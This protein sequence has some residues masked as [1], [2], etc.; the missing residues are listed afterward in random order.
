MWG[1]SE[2]HRTSRPCVDCGPVHGPGPGGRFR[3]GLSANGRGRALLAG[4]GTGMVT[5][6]Q[7][8][9]LLAR[10]RIGRR[11]GFPGPGRAAPDRRTRAGGRP[12]RGRVAAAAHR[13]VRSGRARND[14]GAPGGHGRRP[15]RASAGRALSAPCGP[16]CRIGRRGSRSPRGAQQAFDRPGTGP[17]SGGRRLRRRP[18]LRAPSFLCDGWRP[19]SGRGFACLGAPQNEHDQ[20]RVPV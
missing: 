7:H 9:V 18:L 6:A 1:Q 11:R 15:R 14:C 5:C 16:F 12:R 13:I 3:R 10:G 17:H 8:R 4:A 2:G 19:G 20:L